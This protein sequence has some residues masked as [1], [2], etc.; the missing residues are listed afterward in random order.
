MSASSQSLTYQGVRSLLLLLP[1]QSLCSIQLIFKDLECTHLTA[2]CQFV[3]KLQ[4]TVGSASY[5][6]LC[7][8][9]KVFVQK[10]TYWYSYKEEQPD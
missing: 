4:D 3:I 2:I 1:E 10:L 9:W 8:S 7:C 5:P 6:K